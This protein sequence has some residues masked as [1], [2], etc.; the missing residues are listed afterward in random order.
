[1]PPDPAVVIKS[2]PDWLQVGANII[3]FLVAIGITVGAYFRGHAK[4]GEKAE[5]LDTDAFLE[6]GPV[7]G[8]LEAVTAIAENMR[9]QTEALKVTS[10]A[11]GAIAKLVEEDFDER[12]V[13][14]EVD[15]VLEERERR[16]SG[17][18]NGWGAP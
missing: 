7:R 1:M 3:L 15:R 13:H 14:R 10:A 6:S 2:L 11:L 5:A 4:G 8:F 17:S 18:A 16:R 12:R 9:L